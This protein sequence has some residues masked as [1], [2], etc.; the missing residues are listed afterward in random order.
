M[1]DQ[2]HQTASK[3]AQLLGEVIVHHAPWT[4][5]QDA[6]ARQRHTERFLE[7]L[8]RHTA[9]MLGPFLQRVLES[10]D[11][12]PEIR[13]LIEDVIEP[14]AQFSAIAG[15]FIY[16]A[17]SQIL[18]TSVAPF[19]QGLSNDIWTRVVTQDGIKVPVPPAVLATAVGRGLRLGDKTVAGDYSWAYTEANKSGVGDQELDLQASLVGLP[20][21]LQ[22][23]FELYRRGEIPL[24]DPDPAVLSVQ[25]GL[26]EGD[27]RDDWIATTM[28]L[29]HG[30]LTP[31]DFVRAAVQAQ[32]PFDV[33][34]SWA[35]TTG[36]DTSGGLVNRDGVALGTDMFTLAHDIA[37]R[38]PGPQ[39]LGH[40]ANRGAVNPAWGV[41]WTG[42]GPDALT[43]QQGIAES[44]IK[45]KWTDVLRLLQVYFPPPEQV[46]TLYER[47]A[48]SLAAARQLW[49]AA[50]VPEAG[51]AAYQYTAE[52]QHVTQEKLEAKTTVLAAYYDQLID[53]PTAEGLLADLGYGPNVGPEMLAVQDF[54]REI[55]AVDQVVKRIQTLYETYKISAADAQAALAYIN[56]PVAQ[57]QGLLGTWEALRQA[58]VRVPSVAEI[59]LAYKHSTITE[60]E[61]LAA[62]GALGYQ[63]RDAA[64][65][66]SA[67]STSTVTP[68][69]AAGTTVTG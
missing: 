8:E 50:G 60:Q 37:G 6:Q 54:R 7:G 47:G 15:I 29:A 38:P 10:S 67:H 45:T 33:A 62:I 43:F 51:Q 18:G 23:L 66:L 21:A 53:K 40:L 65:V 48:I 64:I 17:L 39:E 24:T 1:T 41:P 13:A 19:L 20:P 3:L 59:G 52:Q 36:L 32:L 63:P 2:H 57:Q 69:P 11:P 46:T 14:G 34:Q 26:Q 12:P 9:S 55:R 44:D 16:G 49:T 61:A 42:T 4:A 25:R 30:Y 27:F 58:P 35:K 28:K 56:I 31:L 5:E 68:L 22:E